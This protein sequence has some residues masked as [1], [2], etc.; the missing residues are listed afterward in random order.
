MVG[1]EDHAA[2]GH[3]LAAARGVRRKK[4]SIAGWSEGPRDPVHERV[5]A[6]PACAL[7]VRATAVARPVGAR[8]HRIS[9]PEFARRVT[10]P[11]MELQRSLNGALAGAV[12]GGGLG[13]PAAARQEG[14]RSRLRR[15]RAARQARHPR[16]RLAGRRHRPAPGQ[17]RDLRRRVRP[18][19]P[20]RARAADA[21]GVAAGLVEHFGLWPLATLVDRYHPARAELE[22]L[23]GQPPRL[24]PGHL[25][26]RAVRR[27]PGRARAAP[28]RRGRVR[29]PEDVPVSSNGHGNIEHAAVGASE[30]RRRS[31]PTLGPAPE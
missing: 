26:P 9:V 18:A 3:V 8:R 24:R 11:A 14:L 22:P 29:A 5:H 12:G 19:A 25:A 6:A 27:G 31:R 17:R 15:R 4:T 21:A 28:E 20:V 7:V 2:V 1:G 30:P 13:R 10:L 16:H 23:R